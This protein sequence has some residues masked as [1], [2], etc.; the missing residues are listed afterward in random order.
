MKSICENMS[1]VY[2]PQPTTAQ[3]QLNE[4][5]FRSAWNFP[6]AC[7]AMDGKHI[8]IRCPTFSGSTYFNCKNF[9]S[10]AL[11]AITGPDYKFTAVDIG[12]SGSQSDGGIFGRSPMGMALKSGRMG[13]PSPKEVG[14]VSLPHVILSDDAFSLKPYNMKPYPGKFLPKEERIFN[15]RL[16]RA[17]MVVENSFGILAARWRIF[18]ASIHGDLDLVKLIVKTC[19]ILHNFL[20]TEK[21]LN[22]ITVDSANGQV[23]GNWR[24]TTEN[25]TGVQSLSSKGSNNFGTNSSAIR[26]EFKDYFNREGAVSWQDSR[27]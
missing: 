15:Y 17:R 3:W 20:I 18:H 23:R 6:N 19:V 11:L 13:L 27:I 7:E 12:R 24:S 5:G 16:S 4:S 8:R 9:F 22:T 21:D 25:D 2:L 1:S 10:I 14:N 26:D